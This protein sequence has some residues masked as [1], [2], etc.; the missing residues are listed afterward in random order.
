VGTL[1]NEQLRVCD[2][3]TNVR[4]GT[5]AGTGSGTTTTPGGSTS[6]T[7]TVQR[8]DSLWSI[9]QSRG[10]TLTALQAAN[11]QITN[12]SIIRVGE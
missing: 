12:P 5:S 4:C 1:F 9:T 3:P 8:G 11:P 7:Y 2:L 6:C 10:V